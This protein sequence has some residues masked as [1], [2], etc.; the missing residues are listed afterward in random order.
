MIGYGVYLIAGALTA[1]SISG[2]DRSKK[3]LFS[4]GGAASLMIGAAFLASRGSEKTK[5]LG[6]LA[7]IILPLLFAATFFWRLTINWSKPL[8]AT[9]IANNPGLALETSKI[10]SPLQNWLFPT[11]IAVSI[12]SFVLI[13]LERRKTESTKL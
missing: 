11:F 9:W 3:A 2:W 10:Q 1:I 13:A 7:G 8:E 12:L 4:S 6:Q 5:K